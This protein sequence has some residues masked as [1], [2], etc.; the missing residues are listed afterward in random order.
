M[1]QEISSKRLLLQLPKKMESIGR[2]K[3]AHQHFYFSK[4][5]EKTLVAIKNAALRFSSNHGA[6]QN[7]VDW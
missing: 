7:P 5:K 3:G 2:S 4:E 1:N 6:H